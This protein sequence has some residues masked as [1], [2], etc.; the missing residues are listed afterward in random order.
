V[1]EL[2]KDRPM[3]FPPVTMADWRAHVDKE[4]AG[5]PFDKVLVHRTP[6]GLSIAPLYTEAPAKGALAVDARPRRFKI[7]MRQGAKATRDDMLVD[8]TGGAEA[9]WVVAGSPAE[10]ESPEGTFL[11]IEPGPASIAAQL[12]ELLARHPRSAIALAYDPLGSR[13]RT[14]STS[15]VTSDEL[16]ALG[17]LARL[18]EAS[19]S[20]AVMVSTVPYHDAGADGAAEIAFALST[21]ARYLEEL[22]GA[23][24][25]AADA[26]RTIA[27]QLSVGRDTFVELCKL[28]ALRACWQKVLGAAGVTA[29]TATL[30]HA[31]CSSRTLTA[32]DPWVNMLRVT[33]QVFS[34]SLGGA[35]LITPV[36]FDEALGEASAHG[37]RVARNTGLILREE[38]SLGRV[39]D[40]AGGSYYLES[41]TDE[42][43]RAAWTRF[44]SL[45]RS[46]GI[47]KALEDGSLM[48][49]L[50][51]AWQAR[52]KDVATRKTQVLG[53]SEFANLDEVVPGAAAAAIPS[54]ARRDS[55]PFEALRTRAAAKTPPPEALLV[56]LGPLAESRARVGFASGFFAAGGIRPREGA[57]TETAPIV[58]LCGSDERYASDAVATARTLKA[59]GCGTLLLAGKPGAL[60]GALREAGVDGFIFVG[61]D[62]A[63]MLSELLGDPS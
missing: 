58:C 3:N 52:L 23:G 13:A 21:G 35:D 61:C 51:A 39:T 32:R 9:L 37:R 24:L 44:Q 47:A 62:V 17:S 29:P 25:S 53:V 56:P 49:E 26:A 20:T 40:P 36:A 50:D 38:S 33:T 2:Q 8:I 41:V 11:V 30:L 55:A 43:A 46:G 28:R 59:S 10:T 19:G 12:P 63:A 14:R 7:C 18:C 42:L 16:A 48:T 5:R 1:N 15:P 54:G 6:E 27:F 34:A 45:E 31:V 4:L 22:L 57:A 60:E